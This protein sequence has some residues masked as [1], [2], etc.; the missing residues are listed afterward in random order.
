M[1]G[2][3]FATP[4]GDDGGA[5]VAGGSLEA[6]ELGPAAGADEQPATTTMAASARIL[7]TQATPSR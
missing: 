1:P 6:D 7:F 2:N 4:A 5:E 3:G